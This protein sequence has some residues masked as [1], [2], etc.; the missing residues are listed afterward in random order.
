MT[1]WN[2]SVVRIEKGMRHPNADTLEVFTVLG[3]YPV[4]SKEN[5][6]KVG[7]LVGYLPIETVVPDT[8]DFY[9]LCPNQYEK[10]EENGEV[11]QR[12]IGPKYPVGSVPEKNR[13]IKAKKLLGIYSQGLLVPAPSGMNEG[14]SLVEFLG[15]KKFEEEEEDNIQNPKLK[16][17]NAASPPSGW[18][19]PYYDIE[20]LRKYV[21]QLMDNEPIVLTEKLN[22]SNFS[23]C[24]DGEKLWVKSRNFYKKED[25]E[26]M[27]WDVALRMGLKEKLVQ[28][29]MKIF[30]GELVGQVKGF[31]YDAKIDKGSLLTKVCFFDVCDAKTGRYHDYDETVSMVTGLG[32]EMVPELYKGP[33]LGKEMYQYAEGKSTLSDKTIREGFVLRTLKERF[34]PR[35]QSRFITKLIGEGYNLQK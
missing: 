19:I 12:A 8:Q 9:F 32:L 5:Q 11:K 18:E 25:P 13:R 1:E 4:I 14:D 7:D 16:G 6:F 24:F 22:G 23:A 2:P 26:D 17:K 20:G 21:N 34:E 30:F 29:P 10:Y 33:W 3:D 35:L 28:F 15:L 27:W 31:R